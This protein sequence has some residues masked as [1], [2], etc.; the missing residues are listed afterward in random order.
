MSVG[1]R[2][3]TLRSYLSPQ[4]ASWVRI[5]RTTI[6]VTVPCGAETARGV[7]IVRR[8]TVARATFDPRAPNRRSVKRGST[9]VTG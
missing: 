7:W 3:G 1:E 6:S 9:R 2:L 4:A 8:A 5:P